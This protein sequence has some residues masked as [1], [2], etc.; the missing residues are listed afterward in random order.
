MLTCCLLQ[1]LLLAFEG[2]CAQGQKLINRVG[3]VVVSN[4]AAPDDSS[5]PTAAP[6]WRWS[7]T[8][9]RESIEVDSE[10]IK[11]TS[12][13]RLLVDDIFAAKVNNITINPGPADTVGVVSDDNSLRNHLTDM[14]AKP[15]IQDRSNR[16]EEWLQDLEKE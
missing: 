3:V 16:L 9:D 13:V 2:S 5:T 14:L 4:L 12:N 11:T 10:W 6:S 1:L 15:L 7:G 8:G